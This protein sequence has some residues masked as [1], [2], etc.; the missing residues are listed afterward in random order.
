[1][2]DI[3]EIEFYKISDVISYSYYPVPQELFINPL[4]M[5]E[6]SLE[7]KML[8]AF[9]TNRFNL[10]LKNNWTD[11]NNRI[12]LIYTREKAAKMLRVSYKTI[13]KAFKE[14]IKAKLIMEKKQGQG[15]PNLI[16]IGKMRRIKQICKDVSSLYEEDGVLD[17]SN[18]HTNNTNIINTDN[19]NPHRENITIEEV[20]L[21]CNL[22]D[23]ENKEK[24]ILND[25]INKLYNSA[26][27]KIN[28]L[29]VS[30]TEI[31]DKLKLITKDN[32]IHLV[33]VIKSNS[34]IKNLNSYLVSTL[35]NNLGN[36]YNK[37]NKKESSFDSRSYDES[38]LNKLYCNV[39]C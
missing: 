7:A 5:D 18:L 6:L 14:L 15:K 20:R 1:M 35:Y 37:V 12:Y 8:Y 21:K 9:L 22:N 17:M 39:E 23:F 26:I 13:I 31:K 4:Y 36:S 3:E 33:D 32:L 16:Y 27:L 30:Q 34:N 10:S 25:V 29:T 2:K 28:G 11:S 38:V 24:C 19:I